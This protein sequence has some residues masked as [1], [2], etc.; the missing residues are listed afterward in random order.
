MTDDDHRGEFRRSTDT[1][2]TPEYAR[3]IEALRV[4]QDLAVAIDP[5]DDVCIAATANAEQL[6]ELLR[7]HVVTE[8]EA[9]GGRVPDLPGRGSL[10][11]P[12]WVTIAEKPDGFVRREGVFRT[13][14]RGANEAAHGGTLGLLFDDLYGQVARAGIAE[15]CRTVHLEI[16]FRKVTPLNTP[17]V[18]E[19][20]IERIEG[21]KIYVRAELTD[22]DGTLLAEGSGLMLKLLPGQQ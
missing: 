6:A 15:N 10:L 13:F 12:P 4:V 18:V 19:A 8:W 20:R 21:R 16:D 17:L 7:P 11:Q 3:L 5:P 22:P 9:T 14:H 2:A 1:G